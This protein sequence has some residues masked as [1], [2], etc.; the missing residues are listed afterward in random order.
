MKMNLKSKGIVLLSTIFMTVTSGCYGKS[1]E[2][3]LT[4]QQNQTENKEINF[5]VEKVT[6]IE[7]KGTIKG[8]LNTNELMSVEATHLEEKDASGR[9]RWLELRNLNYATLDYNKFFEDKYT[10]VLLSP[11]GIK[12]VY[13]RIEGSKSVLGLRNLKSGTDLTIG[14]YDSPGQIRWSSNSRYL[15]VVVRDGILIYDVETNQI[16]NINIPNLKTSS[17]FESALISDDGTHCVISL[18]SGFFLIDILPN[19]DVPQNKSD[20]DKFKVSNKVNP[21]YTF[22]NNSEVLF[23]GVKGEATCLYGY[24]IKN[25]EIREI[26]DNIS[27]FA[28]S[29]DMKYIA[30]ASNSVLYIGNLKGSNI[31]NAKVVFKGH[32]G[33]YFAWSEDNNKILFQGNDQGGILLKQ[34]VAELKFSNSKE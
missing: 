6:K 30:Y 13:I 27:S 19:E 8:W 5:Q 10:D 1:H 14:K 3:T 22:L 32:I 16:K 31:T 33:S 20:L 17:D 2:K 21:Y 34:F 28:L 18:E 25:K 26:M 4:V 23:I 9:Y 7:G 15:S 24:N 29:E 12:I 11:D